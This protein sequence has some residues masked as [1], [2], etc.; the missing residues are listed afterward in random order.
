MSKVNKSCDLLVSLLIEA[1]GVC[2]ALINMYEKECPIMH[3]SGIPREVSSI[4]T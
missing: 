3:L 4:I 1:A 2:S